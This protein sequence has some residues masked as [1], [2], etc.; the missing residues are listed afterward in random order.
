MTK[1]ILPQPGVAFYGELR[2]QQPA[3]FC[4]DILC[5]QLGRVEGI[6]K[7]S[8]VVTYSTVYS[9]RDQNDFTLSLSLFVVQ[10]SANTENSVFIASL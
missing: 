8:S 10:L 7:A 9:Y 6:G 2:E 5:P 1:N 3:M 4:S